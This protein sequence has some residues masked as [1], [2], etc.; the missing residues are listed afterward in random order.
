MLFELEDPLVLSDHQ[1]HLL[2]AFSDVPSSGVFSRTNSME[3]GDRL[4]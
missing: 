3:L 2:D 1:L 4:V